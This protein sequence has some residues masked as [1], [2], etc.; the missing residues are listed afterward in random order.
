MSTFNNDQQYIQKIRKMLEDDPNRL[1]SELHEAHYL[2][3]ND[4][5]SESCYE[6]VKKIVDE[7]KIIVK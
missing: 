3:E 4:V 1:I 2:L 5:I 6:K 7:A